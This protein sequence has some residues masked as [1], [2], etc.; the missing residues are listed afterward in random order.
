MSSQLSCQIQ[1]PTLK[2]ARGAVRCST[3]PPSPSGPVTEDLK[4]SWSIIACP[5]PAQPHRSGDHDSSGQALCS[6]HAQTPQALGPTLRQRS[7]SPTNKSTHSLPLPECF[8]TTTYLITPRIDSVPVFQTFR[9]HWIFSVACL[10]IG[11]ALLAFCSRTIVLVS[12][13]STCLLCSGKL[14]TASV[15]SN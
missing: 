13:L 2:S 3:R 15:R 1:L 12:D 14:P 6:S 10:R 7:V 5:N 8:C 11:I 4:E 9:V